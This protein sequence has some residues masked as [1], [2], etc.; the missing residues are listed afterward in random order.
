[1]PANSTLETFYTNWGKYQASLIE[2]ITPLTTEQLALRAAPKL[3]SVGEL[4]RHIAL[5]RAAWFQGALGEQGDDIAK[6]ATMPWEDSSPQSAAELVRLLEMTWQFMNARLERWTETDMAASV[7]A[8]RQ[9]K[10][11]T[12]TR[13]Y[14]IWHLIEH[15]LHHGGEL[16]FTLGMNGLNA[17]KL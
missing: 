4:A 1:M 12:F 17:P 10:E 5:T 13:A 2:A 15:D 11:Y 8:V 14:I 3:R 9:G 6:I 7:K 16:A